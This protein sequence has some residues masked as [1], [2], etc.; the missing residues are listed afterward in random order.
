M[1][2]IFLGH[3][4]DAL[5]S[6]GRIINRILGRSSDAVIFLDTHDASRTRRARDN[7]K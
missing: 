4:Q 5:L 3:L 1:E 7:G 6:D 2:F